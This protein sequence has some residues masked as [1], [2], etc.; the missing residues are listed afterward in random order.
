MT[1]LLLG[2]G[3]DPNEKDACHQIPLHHAAMHGHTEIAN[4]PCG[5]DLLVVGCEECAALV[6]AI[7]HRHANVLALLLERG[8]PVDGP[9]PGRGAPGGIG[10]AMRQRGTCSNT[11]RRWR[12]Y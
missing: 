11:P 12:G 3:F 9:T 7:F 5:V 4:A 1:G 6:W 10:S 2:H 8:A